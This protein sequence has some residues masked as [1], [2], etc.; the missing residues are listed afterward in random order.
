VDLVEAALQRNHL[1]RSDVTPQA[2]GVL[3][4]QARRYALEVVADAQDC[5]YAAHRHGITRADLAMALELRPDQAN[6]HTIGSTAA[7]NGPCG[8]QRQPNTTT[9]HPTK[10]L[11]GN[12]IAT[13]ASSIDR[14]APLTL[15]PEHTQPRETT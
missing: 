7:K 2:F 6:A 10:L 8:A 9:T 13:E 12:P 4:E 3:L 1:S 15:L 5:A 14:H 11:F